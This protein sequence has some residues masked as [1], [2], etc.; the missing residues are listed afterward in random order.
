M[1]C[2]LCFSAWRSAGWYFQVTQRVGRFERRILS[3][4]S[5]VVVSEEVYFVWEPRLK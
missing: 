4:E 2:M 1:M 5:I 3:A